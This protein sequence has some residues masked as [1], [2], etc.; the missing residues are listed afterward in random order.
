MATVYLPVQA[1]SGTCEVGTP[2]DTPSDIRPGPM[3]FETLT[4]LRSWYRIGTISFIDP[5]IT[6]EQSGGAHGSQEDPLMAFLS[7][8]SASRRV[9]RRSLE[10]IVSAVVEEAGLL[11]DDEGSD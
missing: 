2:G 10:E 11:D 7:N 3:M 1:S 5:Q 6:S 9:A 4:L 8:N